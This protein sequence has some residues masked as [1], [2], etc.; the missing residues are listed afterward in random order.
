MILREFVDDRRTICGNGYECGFELLK[1][2]FDSRSKNVLLR[3][4]DTGSSTWEDVSR[5]RVKSSCPVFSKID[6]SD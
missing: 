5:V 6:Y 3:A 4:D 1:P 2:S